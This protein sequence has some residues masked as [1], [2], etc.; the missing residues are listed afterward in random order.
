[1]SLKLQ[2]LEVHKYL[3]QTGVPYTFIDVGYW[4]RIVVPYKAADEGY[5]Q[6]LVREWYGDGQKKSAV[7]DMVNIGSFVARIIADPRT[8]NQYVF[9]YDDEVTM[10]EVYEIGC[11][12]SGEDLHKVKVVVS[13][14]VSPMLS[15][16]ELTLRHRSAKR[17][18]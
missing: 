18:S 15:W 2:K 17:M 11:R 16:H 14:V 8:L 9:I 10:N 12:V 1:M 7:V 13:S 4:M 3:K 5:I 6:N